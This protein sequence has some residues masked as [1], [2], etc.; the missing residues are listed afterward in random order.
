MYIYIYDTFQA[1]CPPWKRKHVYWTSIVDIYIWQNSRCPPPPTPPPGRAGGVRRGRH[2]P[3]SYM[4]FDSKRWSQVTPAN[5]QQQEHV[6]SNS[7]DFSTAIHGHDYVPKVGKSVLFVV[8]LLQINTL[9]KNKLIYTRIAKPFIWPL[10]SFD[11]LEKLIR[12]R[13]TAARMRPS[14]PYLLIPSSPIVEEKHMV[15][16][17]KLAVGRQ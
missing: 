9:L 11:K 3:L 2:Q 10:Q 6:T 12:N 7:R 17:C 13:K 14:D 8:F 4:L 5:V 16:F 15:A 1:T